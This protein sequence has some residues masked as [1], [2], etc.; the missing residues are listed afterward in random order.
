MARVVGEDAPLAW[1]VLLTRFSAAAVVQVCD[2]HVESHS[3]SALIPVRSKRL[4]AHAT[5]SAQPSPSRAFC[6]A[7]TSAARVV[8]ILVG[9][10]AVSRGRTRYVVED[11]A[12]DVHSVLGEA[13]DGG[14]DLPDRVRA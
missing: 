9:I 13:L 8:A 10:P 1:S 11:G 12:L 14:Q 4:V 7:A 2:S 3:R 6:G 5:N